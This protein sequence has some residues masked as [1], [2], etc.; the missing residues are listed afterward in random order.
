MLGSTRLAIRMDYLNLNDKSESE[1]V[2]GSRTRNQWSA[3]GNCTTALRAALGLP[4]EQFSIQAFVGMISDE[5]EQL[6]T[7]GAMGGL[8]RGPHE[9]SVGVPSQTLGRLPP[10]CR[11]APSLRSMC[12]GQTRYAPVVAGA[13]QAVGGLRKAPRHCQ[14]PCALPRQSR[15]T[16]GGEA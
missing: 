16:P 8:S 15:H 6:R 4:P 11:P 10:R 2:Y 1:G 7:P 9:A 12:E 13:H 5:I 3:G 14:N